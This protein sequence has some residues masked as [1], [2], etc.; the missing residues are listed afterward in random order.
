MKRRY[1]AVGNTWVEIKPKVA[2]NHYIV[3][4]IQPYRSMI[5]GTLITSRSQHRNH[6]REHQCV[7]I[8]NDVEPLFKAYD[9]LPDVSPQERHELIRE[10]VNSIP[11]DKFRKMLYDECKRLKG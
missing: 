8:G 10:Q 9:N 7:E 2:N 4:D 3:P 1:K 6:L 11:E 5:D